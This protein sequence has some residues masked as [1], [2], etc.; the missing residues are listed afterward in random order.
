[1]T[2]NQSVSMVF[3]RNSHGGERGSSNKGYEANQ[4]YNGSEEHEF[5]NDA[6]VNRKPDPKLAVNGIRKGEDTVRRGY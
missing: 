2:E 5:G 6:W 1:M 3:I 4:G